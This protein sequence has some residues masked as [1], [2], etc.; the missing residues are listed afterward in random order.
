VA[1]RRWNLVPAAWHCDSFGAQ[2]CES[3]RATWREKLIACDLTSANT[4]TFASHIALGSATQ[5]FAL[6]LRSP[7]ATNR[8]KEEKGKWVEVNALCPKS[9][10]SRPNQ[11]PQN[12]CPASLFLLR[13]LLALNS[14]GRQSR[15]PR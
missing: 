8:W 12:F 9:I 2:G 6:T 5:E 13:A 11:F 3:D 7:L 15:P 14:D 1:N 4:S 10:A